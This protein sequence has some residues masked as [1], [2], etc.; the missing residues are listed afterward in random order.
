VE[1]GR[2]TGLLKEQLDAL[3][4]HVVQRFAVN[5]RRSYMEM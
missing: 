5:L 2:H 1:A 3:G 4:L